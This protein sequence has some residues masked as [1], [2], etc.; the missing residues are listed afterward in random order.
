MSLPNMYS[1]SMLKKM[2]PIPRAGNRTD[3]LPDPES[4]S[5]R[6]QREPSSSSPPLA[7]CAEHGDVGDQEG[8]RDGRHMRGREVTPLGV[9][10]SPLKV[11]I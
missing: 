11:R 4:V 3:E 8:L 2:C 9:R 7:D 1:P 5:G 6:P 10:S